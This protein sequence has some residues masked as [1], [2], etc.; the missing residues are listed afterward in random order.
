M[1]LEGT[2]YAKSLL[3][4]NVRVRVPAF[5]NTFQDLEMNPYVSHREFRMVAPGVEKC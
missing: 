2:N 1:R 4:P 5:F 3:M